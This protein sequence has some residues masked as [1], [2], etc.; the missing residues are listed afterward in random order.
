MY[1]VP[2]SIAIGPVFRKHKML[3]LPENKTKIQSNYIAI[4]P[5]KY[6]NIDVPEH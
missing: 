4:F 3:F 2:F 5:L 6:A 1:Y